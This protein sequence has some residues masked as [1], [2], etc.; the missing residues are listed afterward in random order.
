MNQP[1]WLSSN[2][3]QQPIGQEQTIYIPM[4]TIMCIDLPLYHKEAQGA[5]ADIRPSD[6]LCCQHSVSYSQT[7]KKHL[8]IQASVHLHSN[9]INCHRLVNLTALPVWNCL[10]PVFIYYK[11]EVLSLFQV[12]NLQHIQK[13]EGLQYQSVFRQSHGIRPQVREPEEQ[14]GYPH[15][16]A[17]RL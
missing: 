7:V 3:E 9:F 17:I 13:N 14:K 1:D 10:K 6:S 4:H 16:H 2:T 15:Q 8:C 12:N 5:R 11:Q